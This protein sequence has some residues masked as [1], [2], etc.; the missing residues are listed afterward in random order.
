MKNIIKILLKRFYSICLQ[1]SKYI[2]R[3]KL[4]NFLKSDLYL[5]Q[6]N[7]KN[8]KVLFVGSGGPLQKFAESMITGQ[9]LSIDVD[10]KR[11]PNYVM[12]VADM[13]FKDN[14]FD[15]VLLLEVLEHVDQ[16]FKAAL[17]I[18]RVLKPNGHLIVSTPFT[19]GIHEAPF[20]YWR[21]TKYG[22]LKIFSAFK[23]IKVIERSG[24]FLTIFTLFVR[25]IKSKS[26]FHM[27]L[28]CFLSLISII[29]LPLINLF[30]RFMPNTITT[31]YY[32]T[33]KK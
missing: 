6:K 21:F 25:L 2:S 3:N 28:G 19:F 7:H 14:N 33:G 4:Y 20:D 1:G 30:D 22:L 23:D 18:H 31:G 10:Q 17:E 8:L 26:Y 16:P 11:N 13:N 9:I 32:L 29:F 15:L 27:I 12:S 24:F 5:I